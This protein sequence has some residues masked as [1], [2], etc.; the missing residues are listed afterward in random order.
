MWL[1]QT[2]SGDE[3][4]AV[5]QYVVK[6]VYEEYGNPISLL[7]NKRV[8]RERIRKD[9]DIIFCKLFQI[10]EGS[11]PIDLGISSKE[12]QY[13]KWTAPARMD[14]ALTYKC[15]L[16]C[17]KCYLG[18]ANSKELSTE[19]WL[20]AYETLWSLGIPQ[21]VFTGG[22]PTLRGD[23]VELVSEADEF[24]TGMVTNGTKLKHLA[25]GL[26]DASLDYVQ[27]T[28][29]SYD[30]Q[31]HDQMTTV[32]GSHDLTVSGITESLKAGLQVV[33]NTTLTR[34]NAD[35]FLATM[36]WLKGVGVTNIACN[37]LISS[38]RGTKLK[39]HEGLSDNELQKLLRSA[40]ELALKE[41]IN[42]QWYSPTCYSM[43]NPIDL[44]FGIKQC[45]AAAHNM[46]IAP[47]GN[48]FPCQSW[49]NYVGNILMDDWYSIWNHPTCIKLRTHSMKSQ[50]CSGCVFESSCGGGCPLDKSTRI[51][52]G[53]LK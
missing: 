24:V 10:A 29:E 26:K 7:R 2:G 20:R 4:E 17:M 36:L 44:G 5:I 8:T 3:S 52:K 45:S 27:I 41:R 32:S 31:I 35:Q 6:K 22:E 15:N 50:E 34:L 19:E 25:K 14:L 13:D 12:I 51:A 30:H 18:D 21:I 9:L 48:V 16:K 40:N 37:T 11:C 38:G 39:T 47:N 49:P 43:F 42:L 46:T 33:T 23:I 53:G 28:I 1:Y